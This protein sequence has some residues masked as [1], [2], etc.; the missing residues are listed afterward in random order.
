MFHLSSPDIYNSRDSGAGYIPPTVAKED[1]APPC[2]GAGLIY[3][4]AI[5][6]NQYTA[7][8]TEVFAVLIVK[9]VALIE[10]GYK[11]VPWVYVGVTEYVRNI[12][13][14]VPAIP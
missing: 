4:S 12:R 8:T 10:D 7:A 6:A 5:R 1:D 3:S 13:V 2:P 14:G 9:A 11:A